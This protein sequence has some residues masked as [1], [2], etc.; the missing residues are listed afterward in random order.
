M[1]HRHGGWVVVRLNLTNLP[2]NN[3]KGRPF[4][5]LRHLR[6]LRMAQVGDWPVVVVPIKA[7]ATQA[8]AGRVCAIKKSRAAAQLARDKAMREARRQ[9]RQIQPETLGGSG[10][11]LRLHHAR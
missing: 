11:H 7:D 2:L 8:I 6:R 3:V 9:N 10:L 4:A 5:L 1:L